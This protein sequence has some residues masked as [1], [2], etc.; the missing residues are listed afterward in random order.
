[1]FV[2]LTSCKFAPEAI[3]E[4]KRIFRE[5]IVPAAQSQ[6]GNK[7]VLLLEP[8]D[9]ADDFVSV[10]R[11]RAKAD[12]DAYQSTDLYKNTSDKLAHLFSEEPVLRSYEAE[13]APVQA[14]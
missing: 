6:Q 13:D 10:F 3:D 4:V 5:E 2:Q 9:K 7:G 11:W 8:V 1:M 12:A 14:G